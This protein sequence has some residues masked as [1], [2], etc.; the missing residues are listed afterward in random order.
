VFIHRWNTNSEGFVRMVL[1]VSAF[2]C[3]ENLGSEHELGWQ[4]LKARA[5]TV[6]E[7]YLFTSRHIN[8]DIQEQLDKHNL[9]NVVVQFVDFPKRIDA[10]LGVTIGDGHLL[11]A[12]VWEFRL[13][14]YMLR[15]FSKN[16]FDVGIKST[17]A[18]YRWPSFLWYFSKHLHLDPVSGG[19]GFP[20]RFRAFLSPK[21]QRREFFRMFMQRVFYFDPFVLLTMLKASELHV[22]NDETRAMTPK[23]L[24]DKCVLKKDFIKI[25]VNDFKMEEARKAVSTDPEVLRI[26]HT[27][28]LLEWKGVMIILR[29]LALMPASIK[30]EYTVMGSVAARQYYLDYI[31]QENLN[32]VFVD[33]ETVPRHDLSF[34][35]YAHDLFTFAALHGDGGHAPVEA[36]MH[37]MRLLTLDFSGLGGALTDEDI[38]IQTKAK[39]GEEIVQEIAKAIE[40]LYRE[41]KYPSS[42][43]EN[44]ISKHTASAS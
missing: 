8:P 35:F 19:G 14:F 20:L 21:A 29:A 28:K 11:T 1:A 33:P 36:K 26:F 40:Q 12:Y 31:Q 10:L 2:T 24:R 42:S 7:V 5:A 30:Y 38:C 43:P 41:L 3:T 4:C 13:F 6:D 27:G 17:Y 25:D 44:A 9:D 22:S 18:G 34:Y 32:V 23:F 16:Y 37:G 15:R 39:S